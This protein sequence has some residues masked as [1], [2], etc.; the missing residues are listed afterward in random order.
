MISRGRKWWIEKAIL[1]IILALFGSG[2][3]VVAIVS[4]IPTFVARR[5]DSAKSPP[6]HV[7]INNSNS[8][9]QKSVDTSFASPLPIEALDERI[10]SFAKAFAPTGLGLHFVSKTWPIDIHFNANPKLT[11][12]ELLQRIVQHFDL[13]RHVKLEGVFM[14]STGGL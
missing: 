5:D 8:S 14:W 2:G 1:P 11:S 12:D 7:Q 10:Q 6:L 4:I 3:L 13:S 9:E